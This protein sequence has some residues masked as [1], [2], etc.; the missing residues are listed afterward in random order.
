[1]LLARTLDHA[2]LL[3]CTLWQAVLLVL[4]SIRCRCAVDTY[5]GECCGKLRCWCAQLK[6]AAVL[7][8]S[9]SGK[10]VLL[11]C[12]LGRAVLLMLAAYR[13]SCA[14]GTYFEVSCAIGLRTR[15]GVYSGTIIETVSAVTTSLYICFI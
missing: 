6:D 1:V 7:L 11:A 4:A 8:A 12:I 15:A 10:A 3:A 2:V 5:I 9:T 14:V 13:G